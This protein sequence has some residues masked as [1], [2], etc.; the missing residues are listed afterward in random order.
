LLISEIR[1]WEREW[2]EVREETCP[3]ALPSFVS[4]QDDGK[5]AERVMAVVIVHSKATF[6]SCSISFSP[7]GDVYP[8]VASGRRERG[9]PVLH[10]NPAM[11][12]KNII[13][14][15]T[16]TKEKLQRDPSVLTCTAPNA[17]RCKCRTSPHF[18]PAKNS[19]AGKTKMERVAAT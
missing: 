10:Y 2:G 7:L 17:V 12:I 4:A 16:V 11:P 13:P 6:V 14:G 15:Q 5:G 3:P 1:G 8:S 9:F 19:G 18:H